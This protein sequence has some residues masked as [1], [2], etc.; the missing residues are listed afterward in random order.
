LTFFRPW[1]AL[2]SE[3]TDDEAGRD[4]AQLIERVAQRLVALRMGVPALFMLE[5]TRPLS[6]VAS[7]AMIVFEPIVGAI[8]NVAEYRQ[9]QRLME[10]RGNIERLMNRIEELEDQ[11][12]T[13]ASA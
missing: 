8:F 10:D 6:F 2:P 3:E 5:A 9:F 4:H 1:S 7:Q 11:R 13:G 12:S